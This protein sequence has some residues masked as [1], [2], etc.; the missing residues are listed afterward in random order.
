MR[1]R[2]VITA[3]KNKADRQMYVS[4]YDDAPNDWT[5]SVVP[6]VT[7]KTRCYE[8]LAT[9]KRDLKEKESKSIIRKLQKDIPFEIVEWNED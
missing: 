5:I 9:V 7:T 3:G 8:L 4:S 1:Q 6:Y 2:Y